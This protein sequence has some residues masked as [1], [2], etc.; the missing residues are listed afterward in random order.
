MIGHAGQTGGAFVA[1]VVDL[2]R[3]SGA[4][5]GLADEFMPQDA[6]KPHVSS[7]QL[8]IRR[9]DAREPD[10]QTDLFSPRDRKWKFVSQADR[11]ILAPKTEHREILE[12]YGK[13]VAA[14]AA[15]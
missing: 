6:A 5:V 15:N 9:A 3:N 10:A 12:I 4:V 11:I 7:C 2:G 13:Y 8:Q 1:G 14:G